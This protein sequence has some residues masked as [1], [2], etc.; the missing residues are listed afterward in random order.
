ML[1]ASD[2]PDDIA[3]L[4]ALLLASERRVHERDDQVAGLEVQLNTLAAEIEPLKL[5]IDKL[6]RM[7]FGRRSEKLDHQI[8]QLELQLEYLQADEGDT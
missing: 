4:K 1:T 3:A 6:R 7:Q 5:W 2:L 8:E